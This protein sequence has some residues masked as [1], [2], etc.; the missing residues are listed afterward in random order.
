MEFRLELVP[1]DMKMMCFIS[2]ELSNTA[3][4]F[5][6]FAKVTKENCYDFSRRFNGKH[7]K[8]WQPFS[9]QKRLQDVQHVGKK[10]QQLV[11]KGLKQE[12][13]LNHITSF[14]RNLESRQEFVP[15]YLV[16]I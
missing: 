7:K 15:P 14:I 11:Q 4:Y 1:N 16:I 13:I 5:S 12:T 6:S 8:Y 2:G 10:K 9:Y 3:F